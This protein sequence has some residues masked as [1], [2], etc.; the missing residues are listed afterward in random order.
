MRISDLLS[1]APNPRINPGDKRA[2]ILRVEK[3]KQK[4]QKLYYI[5][6]Q[7]KIAN[8]KK[9][10][11][12]DSPFPDPFPEQLDTIIANYQAEIEALKAIINRDSSAIPSD[13]GTLD[14]G[15]FQL[16]DD[17]DY[18]PKGVVKLL[19]GIKKKLF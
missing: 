12:S 18:I 19:D 17:P 15:V 6:T 14:D 2:I 10:K 3:Y 13:L 11:N 4:L 9:I 1:E 16:A 5:K 7:L 8:E